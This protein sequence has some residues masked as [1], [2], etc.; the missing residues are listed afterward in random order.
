MY[1]YIGV[2]VCAYVCLHMPSLCAPLW[3][4]GPELF[5]PG[6]RDPDVR[7]LGLGLGPY[8]DGRGDLVTW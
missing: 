8:L 7:V 6:L 3:G 5:G 1:T 2:C 4:P